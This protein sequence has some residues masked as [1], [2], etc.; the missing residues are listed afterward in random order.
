MAVGGMFLAICGGIVLHML[1][2]R[3]LMIISGVGFLLCC[4]LF[5]VLPVQDNGSPSSSFLY[6]AY[7]F[8]AMLCST[9]GVDITFNVTNIY[10]TTSMPARL[11]ATASGLINSILY[12]AIAFWLGIGEMAVSLT[13][14]SHEE[15]SLDVRDQ[16]RI[17]FWTGVG[18]SGL[19]MCFIVT[20]SLGRASA[21]MTADEKA[22]LEAAAR[23]ESQQQP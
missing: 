13:V 8:P 16:Y 5:A 3:I 22:E 19:A 18:L 9:I 2:G 15:G 12:L 21:E 1:S 11:Q 4:L 17:G 10:I 14:R 7:V 23:S 6:W 20:V